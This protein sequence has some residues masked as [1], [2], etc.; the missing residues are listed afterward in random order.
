MLRALV[1]AGFVEPARG[2]RRTLLFSFQDLIVLRA[3]Q[4]LVAGNVPR[5]RIVSALRELRRQLPA[6]MPLSGLSIGAVGERVVV[7]EGARRWQAESGQ[8]LLLFDVDAAEVS[9]TPVAAPSPPPAT[10]DEGDADAAFDEGVDAEEAGQPEAALAAYARA[11]AIDATHAEA[12][13]NRALMLHSLRRLR[14]AGQAYEEALRSCPDSAALHYNHALFLEDAGRDEEA[15]AAYERA[16]AADGTFADAH[17]NAAL[18][19]E[20]LGRPKEAIRH[21]ARYR[22]LVRGAPSRS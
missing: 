2:P 5:R 19:C 20:R 11:I 15:I 8:Y 9:A 18:L 4:S 10:I 3:A 22:K 14:E 6:S 7:R 16:V 13:L 21:M 12:H 1:A 17:H